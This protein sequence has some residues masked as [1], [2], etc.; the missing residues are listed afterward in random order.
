M[1]IYIYQV[2]NTANKKSMQFKQWCNGGLICLKLNIVK[3]HA[4]KT[5]E[6]TNKQGGRFIKNH[7]FFQFHHDVSELPIL[8]QGLH[9]TVQ[10]VSKAPMKPREHPSPMGQKGSRKASPAKNT[11][12]AWSF[13]WWSKWWGGREDPQNPW[14]NEGFKVFNPQYIWVIT[15]NP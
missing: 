14:K 15:Y 7:P 1:Y 13:G 11:G 5:M 10:T 9:L 3:M 8:R 2:L 12:K 6:K 4:K